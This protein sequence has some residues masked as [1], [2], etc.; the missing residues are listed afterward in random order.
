[1]RRSD[2][3]GFTLVELLVVIG[4]IGLLAALLLPA[5]SQA[6]SKAQRVQCGSNLRQF[7]LV[8]HTYVA[9]ER[10]YPGPDWVDELEQAG[11]R[12][13][14]TATNFWTRGIWRC[15]SALWHIDFT[16][17][18]LQPNYYG[19]NAFGVLHVGTF[20]NGNGLGLVGVRVSGRH[21]PVRETEVSLPSDMIAIGDSFNASIYLMH[22]PSSELA[23]YGNTFSRHQAKANVLFCDGHVESPHLK[24]LFDD[25]SDAALRRW[26]R[27]H[28]PHPDRL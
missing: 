27:D 28:L 6:K 9:D 17:H 18:H 8:L 1:M 22:Q 16:A 19:Y 23:R 5:L 10:V 14:S 3:D 11:L 15:P 21:V 26:N 13:T 7:G 12:T 20:T 24:L 4:I 2:Q 25:S